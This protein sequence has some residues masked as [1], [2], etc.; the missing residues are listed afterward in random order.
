MT[1]NFTMSELI[2]SETAV[3]YNINNMPDLN[4]MD[5]LLK[6]IVY[7]LQP[8]REALDL[9]IIIT[10]GY[11]SK[12]LNDKLKG[13]NTSQHLKGQAADIKIVG[14]TQR[15]LFY[16][17]QRTDIEYDQLIW[18]QDTNCIH[19]SYNHGKNRNQTLIRGYDLKYAELE[20]LKD[21]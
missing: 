14:L 7:C 18:E 12:A 1:L 3:L 20:R 8:L 21:C 11:R 15:D 9:P 4:A 17:I 19:I 13:S 2:H 5:E 6:L 16:R 10:S